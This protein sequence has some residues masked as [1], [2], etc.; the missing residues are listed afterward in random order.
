[1]KISHTDYHPLAANEA[2]H[3]N[4]D[5][6]CKCGAWHKPEEF[7]KNDLDEILKQCTFDEKALLEWHNNRNSKGNA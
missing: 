5:G 7:E 2:P 6:P 3:D 4:K 1:M